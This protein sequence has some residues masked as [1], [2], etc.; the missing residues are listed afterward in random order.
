M[1]CG[2]FFN[3]KACRRPQPEAPLGIWAIA[4]G[5]PSARYTLGPVT[6]ILSF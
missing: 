4:I 1:D 6:G 5:T 3:W 2:I